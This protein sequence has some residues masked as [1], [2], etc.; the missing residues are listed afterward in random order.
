M[1]VEV[2]EG[3]I[4]SLLQLSGFLTNW[5]QKQKPNVG[6][7]NVLSFVTGTGG[8]ENVVRILVLHSSQQEVKAPT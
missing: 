2:Q 3:V 7:N 8:L 6:Q 4:K 5:E 1:S